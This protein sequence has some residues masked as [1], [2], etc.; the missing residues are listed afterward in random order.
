MGYLGKALN[1][2]MNIDFTPPQTLGEAL[3][4]LW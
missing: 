1:H 4:K 2:S 3:E